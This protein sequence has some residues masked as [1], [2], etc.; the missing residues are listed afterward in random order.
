QLQRCEYSDRLIPSRA[1]SH[2]ETGLGLLLFDEN[3]PSN[4][5]PVPGS[6]PRAREE[7]R[8]EAAYDRLLRSEL[9]GPCSPEPTR[10]GGT[11]RSRE[12][13]LLVT[14]ERRAGLF[15]YKCQL[16]DD[17]GPMSLSPT[18]LRTSKTHDAPPRKP[19]RKIPQEPFRVLHA[20]GLSD[21]YYLSLLDYSSEDVLA[22]GL[23]SCIDLWNAR[24]GRAERLSNLGSGTTVA[25][26]KWASRVHHRSS[27][28]SEA[29]AVGTSD[30]KVQIWDAAVGKK[31]RTLKG[32]HR[33]VGA[34]AWADG[35]STLFTGAQDRDILRW[36]L[37]SG[38]CEP[39]NRLRGHGQE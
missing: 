35:S 39:A 21:D 34:L 11:E 25:S 36:D 15:R 1:A 18:P 29:L 16:E 32:H 6:R 5:S 9:L 30:G 14:P 17:Q 27:Q 8:A 4:T 12:D 13:E 24:S 33:R 31:V 19:A 22:V 10:H 38:S 23:G 37:R 2:L 26:V 20:P 7:E 28:G 3:V